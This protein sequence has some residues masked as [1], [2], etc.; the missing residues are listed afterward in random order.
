MSTRLDP[1]IQKYCDLMEEVKRRVSVIDFF[2]S[3]KGR[4]L[5]E[6]PALESACLQIRKILELIAFGSLVANKEAYTSV[7]SRVSRVW[8][9]ADILREL[10]QV[11]PQFYPEPV[12][13]APSPIPG[14][15]RELKPRAPDYLSKAD[16]EE[17]YGRCGVM[18]HAPNP[19][20]RGMDFAYYKKTL[21]IWRSKIMNL[22]NCHQMHLVDEV[23]FYVV[24]MREPQDNKVHFY[25]FRPPTSTKPQV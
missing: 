25:K 22:L 4:T 3:G 17:T 11:N 5:Y 9:A 19:F 23:G 14:V 16:F 13:E 15:A 21:P 10:E 7:Y 8:H 1:D 24:H 2:L 18:A 12:I 20:G 6:A